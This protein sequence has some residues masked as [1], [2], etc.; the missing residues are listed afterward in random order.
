MDAGDD[1]LIARM[2]ERAGDPLRRRDARP[3]RFEHVVGGMS[4]GELRI[5]VESTAEALARLV[6]SIQSGS[7][8]DADLR[9]RAQHVKAEM[10][11]PAEAPPL[12]APAT[13]A[14][15]DQVQS[16]LG[17]P[18][19]DFLRRLYLE[20]AD[21][22]FGPGVGLLS[23]GEVL[24]AHRDLR[25]SPPSEA[26]DDEWPE[27][28]LPLV[29]VDDVHFCCLDTCSGHILETDYDEVESDDDVTFRLAVR[30]IAP[31]LQAWLAGWLDAAPATALPA[32]MLQES[33]IE[34]ARTARAHIAGM[35]PQQRAEMGLPVKG[36]EQMVWGG[37]GLEPDQDDDT[38]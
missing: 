30:E 38:A 12:P 11:T 1:A 35:T 32:A 5:G 14:A 29:A 4:A 15:L 18:L 27:G 20:V 33:M 8:I 16:Q 6:A 25:S 31:S 26:E 23:A 2:R 37:L 17:I 3:M 22:G 10:S 13:A 24:A 7:P 34:A 36:W 19:P 9:E 21:G 28:L